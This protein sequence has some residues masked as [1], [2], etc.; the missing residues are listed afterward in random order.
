MVEIVRHTQRVLSLSL[1]E[2]RVLFWSLFLLPLVALQLK[3][4]G[5]RKTK[6][7][8][9]RFSR[10]QE[11]I[12]DKAK[13]ASKIAHDVASMVDIIAR[14]G[15]YRATCLPTSLATWWISARQ[16]VPLEIRIGVQKDKEEFHAHSW[17]ELNG[18]P[19]TEPGIEEKFQRL[20]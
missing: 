16:G 18:V 12:P 7:A 13:D 17:V 19:V 5:F 9:S 10:N 14:R 2:W 1:V 20:V 3:S 8:L 11:P 4:S 6:D 15:P